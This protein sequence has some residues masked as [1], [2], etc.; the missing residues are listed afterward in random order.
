MSTHMNPGH[1][2]KVLTVLRKHTGEINPYTKS[3][4][5]EA[6]SDLYSPCKLEEQ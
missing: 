5:P 3:I 4:K 2:Q 1:R 6:C